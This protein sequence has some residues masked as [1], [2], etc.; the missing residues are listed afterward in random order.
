[1][2]SQLRWLAFTCC[3]PQVQH[4]RLTESLLADSTPDTGFSLRSRPSCVLQ[5]V[6]SPSRSSRSLV[7]R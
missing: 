1:V 5:V 6:C 4:L 3:Q 7:A 2:H